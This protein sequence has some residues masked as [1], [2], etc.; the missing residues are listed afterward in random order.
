MA[1]FYGQ[2]TQFPLPDIGEIF[3]HPGDP[4]ILIKRTGEK[5]FIGLQGNQQQLA[6]LNLGS[7]R[8]FNPL[9]IGN[10]LGLRSGTTSLPINWMSDVSQFQPGPVTAA[11][12]VLG[13]QDPLL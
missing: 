7:L 1:Q 11:P 10:A 8:T 2:T 6:G 4:N 13:T 12:D 3:R 9:D 5:S